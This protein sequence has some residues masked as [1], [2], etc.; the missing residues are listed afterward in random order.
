M[1]AL[2]LYNNVALLVGGAQ[3]DAANHPDWWSGTGGIAGVVGCFSMPP[4]LM[5]HPITGVTITG[6]VGI[7][8]P[9][10]VTLK[11]GV[12]QANHVRVPL[13][14]LIQ[15]TSGNPTAWATMAVY[16]DT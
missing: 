15:S 4:T 5:N 7:V 10:T 1:S 6:V 2:D 8:E 14:I 11:R 3:P 9:G 13:W 12:P 16:E